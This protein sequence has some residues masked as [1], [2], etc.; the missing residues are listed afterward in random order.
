MKKELDN[1]QEEIEILIAHIQD[2]PVN[3]LTEETL[4]TTVIRLNLT[5]LV[6]YSEMLNQRMYRD[7]AITFLNYMSIIEKVEEMDNGVLLAI[8]DSIQS[9]F[10]PEDDNFTIC[11]DGREYSDVITMLYH[12][13]GVVLSR[14]QVSFYLTI[15]EFIKIRDKYDDYLSVTPSGLESKTG[16]S[17]DHLLFRIMLY[18][19][20][21][22]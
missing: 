16:F 10:N 6:Q 9:R 22:N 17:E 13:E 8:L 12:L 18:E 15:L 14:E 4:L 5:S 1:T 19:E 3:E 2:L 11:E 20:E 7:D 21:L